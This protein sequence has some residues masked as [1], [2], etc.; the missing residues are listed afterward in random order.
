MKKHI[1]ITKVFGSGGSNAHLKTLLEYLGAE[2]VILVV[3]SSEQADLFTKVIGMK[4]RR[5]KIMQN[6]HRYAAQ[7]YLMTSN[8]KEFLQISGS[9]L[10]IFLLSASYGFAGVTI[11]AVESEKHIYLLRLPLLR[12]TYILHSE[13]GKKLTAFTTKTCNSGLSVRKNIITV[14][15]SMKRSIID[16]WE[17]KPSKEQFIRVIYNCV[18]GSPNIRQS[19]AKREALTVITL[20]HA[21]QRKNPFLWLEVAKNV[22]ATLP[23]TEFLWL[24][25]GPLLENLREQSRSFPSIRFLG[26]IENPQPYL[27]K[28]ALYYQPSLIEPHGIAVVEAMCAGLPCVVSDAGGLP[29][30][31]Q[32]KRNGLVVGA[33]NLQENIDALLSII[34]DRELRR[35]YGQDS[36]E[37]Y[38]ALFTFKHFREKMDA[39]YN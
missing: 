32:H 23:G 2:N 26:L 12:V 14:S 34:R 39:V 6:L 22:T 7:N 17:I 18:T 21:D 31:V 25:D 29:E 11:S 30:S 15:E 13:P 3:E 20:G 36:I 37:R 28:A 38:N 4:V 1:V 35:L 5:I 8:V 10:M 27:E 16:Q 24:G 19:A 9:L 33:N